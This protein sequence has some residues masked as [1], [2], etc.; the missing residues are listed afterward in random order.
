MFIKN[1]NNPTLTLLEGK[2]FFK[3]FLIQENRSRMKIMLLNPTQDLQLQTIENI[4]QKAISI[5][6]AQG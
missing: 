6:K 5:Y 2:H 4:L 1:T 3:P